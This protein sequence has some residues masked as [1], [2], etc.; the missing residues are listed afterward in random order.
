M[1]CPVVLQVRW[2]RLVPRKPKLWK[3]V[4][5]SPL[6]PEGEARSWRYS[7]DCTRLWCE[8]EG[9]TMEGT[10]LFTLKWLLALS[11]PGALLPLTWFYSFH[12]RRLFCILFL[13]R[14]LHE[15]NGA[16]YSTMLLKFLFFFFL[17]QLNFFKDFS[18]YTPNFL[19]SFWRSLVDLWTAV[20]KIQE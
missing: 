9:R 13:R 5:F 4:P 15:R 16:V 6:P 8:D 18:F 17:I 3:H 7:P 1:P 12:K 2:H 19:S 20:P 11:S 10:V 14:C